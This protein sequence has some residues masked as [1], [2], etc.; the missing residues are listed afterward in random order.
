MLVRHVSNGFERGDAYKR[1]YTWSIFIHSW[2]HPAII[3]TSVHQF[4]AL[5]HKLLE[6][7]I[8][9]CFFR[10][11]FIVRIIHFQSCIKKTMGLLNSHGLTV[12]TIWIINNMNYKVCDEIIYLFPNYNGTAVE[13]VKIRVSLRLRLHDWMTISWYL[14]S[15]KD[16]Y[17]YNNLMILITSLTPFTNNY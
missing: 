8:T 14:S 16:I 10:Y 13:N 2:W 12:T 4:S 6:P 15:L 11:P 7:M 5:W 17:I 9:K 1:R 3:W